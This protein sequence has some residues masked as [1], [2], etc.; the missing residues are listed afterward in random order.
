MELSSHFIIEHAHDPLCLF[1]VGTYIYILCLFS[2]KNIKWFGLG[3]LFVLIQFF[4]NS[5]WQCNWI[6]PPKKSSICQAN[7]NDVFGAIKPVTFLRFASVLFQICEGFTCESWHL[8]CEKLNIGFSLSSLTSFEYY[9]LSVMVCV[10]IYIY[11]YI[12]L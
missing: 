9:F 1:L 10:Y 7:N 2:C 8:I 11:I 12:S 3:F 4:L 5:N 6:V